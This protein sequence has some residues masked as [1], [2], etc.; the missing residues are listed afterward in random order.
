MVNTV[1]QSLKFRKPPFGDYLTA[2][3]VTTRCE[4]FLMKH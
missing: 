2:E 4:E 3:V 1:Q